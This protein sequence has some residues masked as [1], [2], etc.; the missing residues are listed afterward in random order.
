M[1][2]GSPIVRTTAWLLAWTLLL[3]WVTPCAAADRV[4]AREGRPVT[5]RFPERVRIATMPEGGAIRGEIAEP[6]LVAGKEVLKSG[7]RVTLEIGKFE[8]SGRLGKAG[9]AE[10]KEVKALAVDGSEIP[11]R[12]VFTRRGKGHRVLSVI[13]IPVALIGLFIKGSPPTFKAGET[14]KMEV[15]GDCEVLVD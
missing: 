10:I 1:T 15:A 13:L 7:A 8:A 14:L 6:L 2:L 3:L 4:I 11:L 12:P 9:K 5:V